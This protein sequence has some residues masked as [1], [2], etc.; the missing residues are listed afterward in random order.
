MRKGCSLSS[1]T[2]MSIEANDAE[3]L[4][5]LSDARKSIFLLLILILLISFRSS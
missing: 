4:A 3:D 1:E 2:R 5:Q